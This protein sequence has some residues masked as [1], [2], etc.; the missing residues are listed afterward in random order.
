[1]V[2]SSDQISQQDAAIIFY[3]AER[4][5]RFEIDLNNIKE[6]NVMVSSELLKLARI[7]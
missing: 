5:L 6:L 1:M 3:I 7:K 2:L 4:K